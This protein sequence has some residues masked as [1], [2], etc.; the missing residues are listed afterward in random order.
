MSTNGETATRV[1][2]DYPIFLAPGQEYAI[3]AVA[4]TTDEYELWIAE[5]GERTVNTQSLPNAEAVIY[6]KQF[7]LGSL[8][9]SQ[10]GSIWTANQYQDLKFKLYKANFTSTT[11]TAFFYNPTWMKVMDM[12]KHK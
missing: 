2:F 7:A 11:G 4:E 1:T 5:M 9:K 6:S 10:N 3:V 8:F 12:L